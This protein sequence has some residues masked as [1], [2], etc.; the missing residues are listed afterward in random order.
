M[1]KINP[2]E[3]L[4]VGNAIER[5]IKNS[6]EFFDIDAAKTIIT[7]AQ[8]IPVSEKNTYSH[9]HEK[10]DGSVKGYTEEQGDITIN[11]DHVHYEETFEGFYIE[12]AGVYKL[13]RPYKG[14]IIFHHYWASDT[15]TQ[16]DDLRLPQKYFLFFSKKNK[17]PIDFGIIKNEE[18]EYSKFSFLSFLGIILWLLSFSYYRMII[19]EGIIYYIV[20]QGRDKGKK[21]N[22]GNFK[23]VYMGK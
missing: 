3:R 14:E 17:E 9:F 21:I 16:G 18:N 5:L 1:E 12:R 6:N 13:Y 2:M 8:K 19:K 7:F 23:S 22:K 20:L 4:E 10:K 11:S 15:P